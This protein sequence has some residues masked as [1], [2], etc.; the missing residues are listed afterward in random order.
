MT[1][2][3]KITSFENITPINIDVWS[4]DLDNKIF[5][6]PTVY[7][8]YATYNE[9]LPFLQQKSLTDAEEDIIISKILNNNIINMS[10]YGY[11][12]DMYY[13]FSR[14][15]F[16]LC[17]YGNTK[18][19]HKL[20]SYGIDIHIKLPLYGNT[21]LIR[22]CVNNHYGI[23]KLLLYHGV[24]VNERNL[25]NESAIM[26]AACKSEQYE[27]CKLLI[28][29]GANVNIKNINNETPLMWST[30]SN[31]FKLFNLILNYSSIDTI[32]TVS[33]HDK[34]IFDIIYGDAFNLHAINV[35]KKYNKNF[36]Y[37]ESEKYNIILT[38]VLYY[39]SNIKQ[40]KSI[41]RRRIDT[42]IDYENDI[43]LYKFKTKLNDNMTTFDFDLG[44]FL[45]KSLH[46]ELIH[47]EL[48]N[49]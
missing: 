27:I 44:D 30:I 34:S 4:P 3:S 22:A 29:Y 38:Y 25:R 18:I 10:F 12:K 19:L 21:L 9:I 28:Y 45:E 32:E 7:M 14:I 41:K 20:L 26:W 35:L 17:T 6:S 43:L 33:I 48:I 16:E 23:A 36:S 31:N 2:Y 37:H 1:K 8:Q 5:S 15:V 42:T 39:I 46:N 40:F 13:R 24:N 47:D 49:T 11:Y